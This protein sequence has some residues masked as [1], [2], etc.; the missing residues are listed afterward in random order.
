MRK[1]KEHEIEQQTQDL[2]LNVGKKV[3]KIRKENCEPKPFKS[4]LKVNTIK[5]VIDHPILHIPSY[6]F[7]EDDSYVEC[8]RCFIIN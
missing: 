1:I 5:A 4:G 3:S 6:T 2:T 7:E 8:R